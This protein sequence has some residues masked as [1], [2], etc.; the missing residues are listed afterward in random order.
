MTGFNQKDFAALFG[1]RDETYRRYE[2]GETEPNFATLEK[3]RQITG[4]SLDFIITGEVEN[5]RDQATVKRP[6]RAK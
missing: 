5:S 2:R 4:V 1:L 3:L 6:L